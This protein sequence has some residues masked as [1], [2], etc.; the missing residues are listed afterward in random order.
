MLYNYVRDNYKNKLENVLNV[1]I[2]Q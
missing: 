1:E 2:P